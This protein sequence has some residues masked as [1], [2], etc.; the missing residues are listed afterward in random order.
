MDRIRPRQPTS[1]RQSQKVSDSGLKLPQLDTGW[2]SAVS[3]LTAIES[4]PFLSKALK[5]HQEAPEVNKV[6]SG[7]SPGGTTLPSR[8]TP[9]TR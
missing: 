8:L 4:S 7:I 3:E 6:R 1:P 9:N 5:F 2:G